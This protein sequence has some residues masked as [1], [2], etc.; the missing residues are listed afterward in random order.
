MFP[1][2]SGQKTDS[3]GGSSGDRRPRSLPPL[4]RGIEGSLPASSWPHVEQHLKFALVAANI[5]DFYPTNIKTW[6]TRENAMEIDYVLSE[7]YQAI[8]NSKSEL[9]LDGRK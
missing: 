4:L 1:E 6:P 3:Q 5:A 9:I 8:L 2:E 7:I